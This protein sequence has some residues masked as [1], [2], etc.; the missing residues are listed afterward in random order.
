LCRHRS[1]VFIEMQK[2]IDQG[3]EIK[4]GELFH[5]VPKGQRSVNLIRNDR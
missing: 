3:G 4:F 2:D 5:T 1:E